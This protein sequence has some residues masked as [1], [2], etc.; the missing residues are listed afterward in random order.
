MHGKGTRTRAERI[1]KY[2][3]HK[4]MRGLSLHLA[5]ARSADTRLVLNAGLPVITLRENEGNEESSDKEQSA[6]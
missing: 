3:E 2:V 6:E 5:E 1:E 4:D